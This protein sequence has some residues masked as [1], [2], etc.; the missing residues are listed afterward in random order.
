MSKHTPG[1]WV[2]IPA[3]YPNHE[4]QINNDNGSLVASVPDSR[5]NAAANAQLIAAAPEL[6]DALRHAVQMLGNQYS[7][8]SREKGWKAIE[9]AIAKAE[10]RD[11]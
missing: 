3:S 8:E 2:H 6:L 1:P 5:L 9:K 10:G 11:E 4:H 7:A